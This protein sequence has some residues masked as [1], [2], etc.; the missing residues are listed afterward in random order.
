MNSREKFLQRIDA[1]RTADFPECDRSTD[2]P[3]LQRLVRS[4]ILANGIDQHLISE[5]DIRLVIEQISRFLRTESTKYVRTGN[6][7]YPRFNFIGSDGLPYAHASISYSFDEQRKVKLSVLEV[8]Q[9]VRGKRPQP[10]SPRYD[11]V[12]DIFREIISIFIQ[13]SADL[14][15][16]QWQIGMLGYPKHRRFFSSSPDQKTPFFCPERT[17]ISHITDCDP[18]MELVFGE[19]GFHTLHLLNTHSRAV[20]KLLE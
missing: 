9:G 10:L 8:L 14:V 5:E 16:S 20:R 3:E 2:V 15:Q 18:R 11:F 19:R 6:F 4:R 13:S 7:F 17:S 1:I 12:R